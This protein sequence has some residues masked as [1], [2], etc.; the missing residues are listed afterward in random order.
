MRQ[1]LARAVALASWN[2]AGS[3]GHWGHVQQRKNHYRPEID[4]APIDGVWKLVDLEIL[5]EERL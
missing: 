2:G 4:I 3:V 1:V 5:E